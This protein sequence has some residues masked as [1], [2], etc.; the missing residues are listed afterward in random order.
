[1]SVSRKNTKILWSKFFRANLGII[2]WGR[3]NLE[4]FVLA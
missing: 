3:E 4:H 2:L 1:M